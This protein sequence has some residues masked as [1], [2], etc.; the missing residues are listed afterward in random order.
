MINNKFKNLKPVS[1]FVFFIALACEMIFIKMRST[2]SRC[3]IGPENMLVLRRVRA[4]FCSDILQAWVVKGL[5]HAPVEV[6]SEA[7]FGK[8]IHADRECPRLR[9]ILIVFSLVRMSRKRA[10]RWMF[11]V[12]ASG[13]IA[14]LS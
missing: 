7:A 9:D 10:D 6:G 11:P 14:A 8:P 2:E 4:S 12:H 3:V 13:G 5:M 1:L